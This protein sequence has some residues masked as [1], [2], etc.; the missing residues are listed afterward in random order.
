MVLIRRYESTI[1]IILIIL[2]SKGEFLEKLIEYKPG[3]P[4]TDWP[5]F[6]GNPSNSP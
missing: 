6:Y 1:I 5:P 2:G 3:N 4:A